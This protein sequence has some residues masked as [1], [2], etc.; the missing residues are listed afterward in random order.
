MPDGGFYLWMR[1]PIDDAEFVRRLHHEY[2]VLVL[3]GS[4][5][6]REVRGANPG[7]N[8]IRIALVA[9][10]AECV[11]AA[12]RIDAVRP[13]AY[14]RQRRHRSSLGEPA[15]TCK[16]AKAAARRGGGSHRRAR[17]RQAARRREDRAASG[18]RTS[19]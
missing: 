14:E 16:P 4:Y 3:P 17:L 2:N 5:L 7:R 11:E 18:S 1:T 12:E 19:G 8:H 6:G 10:L 15:P 9:P 13:Q